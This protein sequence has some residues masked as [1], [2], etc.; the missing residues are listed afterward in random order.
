MP[1]AALIGLLAGRTDGMEI[2]GDLGV[3][4]RLL[5]VLQA[6]DPAF[7]IVTP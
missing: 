1:K 3:L 7:A 6:P 4:E 2:E 5:A